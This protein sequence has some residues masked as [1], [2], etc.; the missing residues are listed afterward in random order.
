MTPPSPDATRLIRPLPAK[1]NLE[2]QRK[3]A[4]ALMRAYCRGEAEAMDRVLCRTLP[5]WPSRTT[6]SWPDPEAG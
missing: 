2:K 5:H 6:W 1:P 4:K 3:L